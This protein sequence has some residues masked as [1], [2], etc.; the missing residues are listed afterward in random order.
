MENYKH[1]T[2]IFLNPNECQLMLSKKIIIWILVKIKLE[3]GEVQK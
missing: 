1:S 3:I 2:K